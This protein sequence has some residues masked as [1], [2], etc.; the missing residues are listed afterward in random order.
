M[1]AIVV[2]VNG[3][4]ACSRGGRLL[5]VCYAAE[6][7]GDALD[8]DLSL[9]YETHLCVHEAGRQAYTYNTYVYM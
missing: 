7:F 9:C 2:G 4:V 5:E 1:S 6:P 8:D 3:P